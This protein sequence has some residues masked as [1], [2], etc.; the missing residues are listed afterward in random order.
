MIHYDQYQMQASAE[1]PANSTVPQVRKKCETPSISKDEL[2]Y[3]RRA[4]R[5]MPNS[6]YYYAEIQRGGIRRKVSLETSNAAAAAH[7]AREIWYEVRTLGWPGYMAKYKPRSQPNPD[8]SLGEFVDAVSKVADLEPKTLRFYVCALRKIAADIGG[9]S[10]D[11]RKYGARG[12]GHKAWLERVDRMK[13]SDLNSNAVQAWKVAFIARAGTDPI[14]QRSAR[15]SVNSFMRAAR[16]LFSPRLL[17]HIDLQLPSPTPFSDCEFEQRPSSKYRSS[18]DI[19]KVIEAA[20]RELASTDPEAFKVFLLGTMVGL[21]RKEIDLLEWSSFRWDEGVIRVEPTEFFAPKSED[22]IGDVACD[23]E[24]MGLFRGLATRARGAFVIESD[25][26]P[27]PGALY[28]YYRCK[29]VFVRL[30]AWLKNQGVRTL[31]P[32]HT[33][34][35]EFGSILCA[36]YGIYAASRALRHSAVAVTDQYYT[37]SRKRTSVG[38]GHL[39][40]SPKIVDFNR[41]TA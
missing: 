10:E 33:L 37:D 20:K 14:L 18:F 21:R 2:R 17:K 23:A 35:K 30:I 1:L 3:W 27:Q 6:P 36:S 26:P 4:I 7:R 39:L 22:S 9:L 34:R 11:P 16:S 40:E 8:P 38:L 28:N 19:L 31:K 24:L 32:L 15:V 5:R 13:L 12:K 41:N 29:P 25:R